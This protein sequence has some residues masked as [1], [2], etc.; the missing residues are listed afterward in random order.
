LR[1]F[2]IGEEKRILFT[3][4]PFDGL[5]NLPLPGPIF[6]HAEECARYPEDGGLPGYLRSHR[7]TL[8]GYG[9]GRR[10]H[11]QEYVDNGEVEAVVDRLFGRADIE[12][13]HVHDTEAGCY[14][15]RI[16]RTVDS[17]MAADADALVGVVARVKVDKREKRLRPT[18]E[19]REPQHA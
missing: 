11:K 19:R 7:L 18:S 5:E 9:G 16:E 2:R 6:I 14:D 13:I 12:Y 1:T 4:D 10:L 17:S 15:F 8:N 3:Y